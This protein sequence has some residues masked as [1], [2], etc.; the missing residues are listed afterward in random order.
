MHIIT[1]P[2]QERLS[3][4]DTTKFNNVIL[5]NDH[6]TCRSGSTSLENSPTI[7]PPSIL[8]TSRYS[9]HYRDKNIQLV[10]LTI[11]KEAKQ[12]IYFID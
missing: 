7:V 3:E 8:L 5:I 2:C 12:T 10:E 1:I 6:Q 4:H 11:P 9:D